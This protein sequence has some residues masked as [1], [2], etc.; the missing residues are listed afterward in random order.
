MLVDDHL[1]TRQQLASVIGER[2]AAR[3]A[4]EQRQAEHVLQR[5]DAARQ[6][7]LAEIEHLRRLP[8]AAVPGDGQQVPELLDFHRAP[9]I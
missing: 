2:H 5:A 6:A 3:L 9:S 4:F 8:D 7:R 1:G